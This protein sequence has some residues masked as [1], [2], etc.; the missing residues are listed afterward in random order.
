M[1][2]HSKQ[3]LRLS[4]ERDKVN[5]LNEL[6]WRIGLNAEIRDSLQGY[7]ISDDLLRLRSNLGIKA[8]R[9]GTTHS[10]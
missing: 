9:G 3:L 1:A 2:L 4:Y 6:E 5:W 8:S 7:N 10:M